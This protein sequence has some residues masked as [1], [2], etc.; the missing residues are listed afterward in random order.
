MSLLCPP[1][2]SPAS[3]Q[4]PTVHW[5]DQEEQQKYAWKKNYM[6]VIIYTWWNYHVNAISSISQLF[7]GYAVVVSPMMDGWTDR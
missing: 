7:S 5:E 6:S 4:L 1:T 2:K 3:S